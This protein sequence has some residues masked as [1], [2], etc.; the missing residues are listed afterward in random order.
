MISLAKSAC[1]IFF[2]SLVAVIALLNDLFITACLKSSVESS[3]FFKFEPTAE[4]ALLF[5]AVPK[6]RSLV[7]LPSILA[8]NSHNRLKWKIC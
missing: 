4:C 8:Y 2:A 7:M 5:S 3:S 6:R 1:V